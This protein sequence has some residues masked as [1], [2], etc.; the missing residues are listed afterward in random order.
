M[1]SA[2]DASS[3]LATSIFFLTRGLLRFTTPLEPNEGS[4]PI[5]TPR[6]YS[7]KEFETVSKAHE[8]AKARAKAAE[9]PTESSKVQII[10]WGLEFSR[11]RK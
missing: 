11:R 8:A 3:I 4:M 6:T 1:G 7:K 9:K 2:V 5:L 10:S